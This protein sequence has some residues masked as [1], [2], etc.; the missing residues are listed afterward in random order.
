[1][2]RRYSG[3]EI[4]VDEVQTIKLAISGCLAP[5]VND[6]VAKVGI[7]GTLEAWIAAEVVSEEIMVPRDAIASG[8]RCL[9]M[10]I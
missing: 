5:V 2:D 4:I 7:H 8:N 10:L 9:A 6:I 1:M 3:L